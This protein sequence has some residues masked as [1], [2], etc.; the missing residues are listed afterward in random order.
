MLG[1]KVTGV[2]SADFDTALSRSVRGSMY[3]DSSLYLF[4]GASRR[5]RAIQLF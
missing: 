3:L 5:D 1:T 4:H 2:T